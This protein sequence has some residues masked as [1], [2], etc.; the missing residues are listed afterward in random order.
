MIWKSPALQVTSRL[1]DL[2]YEV[3][4]AEPN[5]EAVQGITLVDANTLIKTA[6]IIAVLVAHK[7][8]KSTSI[9]KK[10][11]ALGCLDFCGLLGVA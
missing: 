9:K 11:E 4:A 7:E 10:L 8:F 2:D 5:V 1:I 3:V 6:D